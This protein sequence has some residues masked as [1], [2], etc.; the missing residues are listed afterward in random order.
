MSTNA[1]VESFFVKD[2]ALVTIA[3]GKKA[4]KAGRIISSFFNGHRRGSYWIVGNL[5]NGPPD[6]AISIRRG[7]ICRFG[8]LC[9]RLG[10]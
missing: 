5:D 1:N 9:M 6:G 3:T 7:I 8:L 4:H 10:L 2:C